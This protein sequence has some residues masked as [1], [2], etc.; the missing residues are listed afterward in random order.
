MVRRGLQN[1]LAMQGSSSG[2]PAPIN[3]LTQFGGQNAQDHLDGNWDNTETDTSEILQNKGNL[4]AEQKKALSWFFL[5][6]VLSLFQN[7]VRLKHE[8]GICQLEQTAQR[9]TL[10]GAATVLPQNVWNVL[11]LC[12]IRTLSVKEWNAIFMQDEDKFD[13]EEPKGFK[14]K[15][16][17][18]YTGKSTYE[19]KSWICTC[20]NAFSLRGFQKNFIRVHW[21]NQFLNLKKHQIMKRVQ[22]QCWNN[23]K[24][25]F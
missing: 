9:E 1:D 11:S 8:E 17:S 7:A 18:I 15:K 24:K 2:S 22:I 4:S 6:S 3:P 13:T 10:R 16:V 21:V 20:E 14:S 23:S 19:L 5:E 25:L 12:T